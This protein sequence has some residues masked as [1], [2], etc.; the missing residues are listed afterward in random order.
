MV[1][2]ILGLVHSSSYSVAY[3]TTWG[4]ILLKNNRIQY[5]SYTSYV[6]FI[7]IIFMFLNI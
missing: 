4:G 1:Y 7:K 3:T 2:C 5:I 6:C